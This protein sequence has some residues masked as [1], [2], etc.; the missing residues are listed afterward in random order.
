MIWRVR[1]MSE[2]C[3]SHS[4]TPEDPVVPDADRKSANK[5]LAPWVRDAWFNIGLRKVAFKYGIQ[6][7]MT[8]D[9][10]QSGCMFTWIQ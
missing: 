10:G 5:R 1:V 3:L 6:V 9:P 8:P 7:E 4:R 2:R